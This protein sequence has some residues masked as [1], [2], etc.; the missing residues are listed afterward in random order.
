MRHWISTCAALVLAVAAT[1]AW[2]ADPKPTK[3]ISD[4]AAKTLKDAYP[5]ATVGATLLNVDRGLAVYYVTLTGDKSVSVAEVT[6]IAGTL[7]Q[8]DLKLDQKDLPD[9]AAKAATGQAGDGAVFAAAD[10]LDLRAEFLPKEYNSGANVKLMAM[11]KPATAYDVTFTK[12]GIKGIVRVDEGG[13]VLAPINWMKRA[14]AVVPDGKLVI[15]VNFGCDVDYTDASGV[16]WAADRM[17]TKENKSGAL[18]G[19]PHHRTNL[20]VLG[21]DAP[22]IYDSERDKEGQFRADVPNGLYTVRMHFCE[23]WEGAKK[24]NLRI[25]GIKI[26]GVKVVDKMDLATQGWLTP[27]VKEWKDVE[28]KDGKLV[29]EPFSNNGM[30]QHPSVEAYEIVQQ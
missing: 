10:K 11:A 8:G 2:A 26:Q 7:M 29:I 28:V 21:T 4:A 15:R 19:R 9:A 18:D 5:T 22:F 17:Y 16:V 27:F 13:K 23:T 25:F 6:A 3:N 24:P 12:D 14:S 20:T 30:D 1:N